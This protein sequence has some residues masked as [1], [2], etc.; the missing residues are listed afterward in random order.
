MRTTLTPRRP[1]ATVRAGLDAYRV[2]VLRDLAHM[3]D[4]LGSDPRAARARARVYERVRTDLDR[5]GLAVA[6]ARAAASYRHV[7]VVPPRLYGRHPAA[8]ARGEA[9]ERVFEAAGV[10]PLQVERL[11]RVRPRFVDDPQAAS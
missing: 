9:F 4:D 10:D 3:S 11:R 6:L 1:T 5:F 2:E 7:P 8:R